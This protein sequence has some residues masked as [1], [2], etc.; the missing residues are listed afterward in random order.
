MSMDRLQEALAYRRRGFSVIPIKPKDKKPLIAWEAYQKEPAEEATIKHWFESWP[1]ANIGLV[2]GAVSDCIVVDLDSEDAKNKLKSL[3][4]DYDHSAVPRSRTGKGWQLFFKHPGVSIPNRAGVLPNVDIRAD[5]GYV[6]VPPSIHPNGKEYKWEVSFNGH[7]PKLPDE[8]FKLISAHSGNTES[9][10]RERFDTAKA[11]AGVPKGQR[12]EAI[13]KLASKLRQADVPSEMTE[14]LVLEAARN[15][16]PPF[17]ERV[18]LDKVAR[19]YQRYE[20]RKQQPA[21]KQAEIWPE[22]LTAKD[23]LQAPKD[24]T[25]WILENCLPV[26][27]GSIVV[28][29]PK[30]GKSTTVVDLC[31]SVARGERFLNRETQQ[32]PVAYLFLDGPLPEIADI[33]V[34]FGLRESD[35]IY[36]HAGSAPR[37]CIDWLLSTVK[38]KGVRLV[39]IDTLQKLLKFKDLNDYAEVTNRMEPLLDAARQGNCHIMMLHHAGKES[40]DDLDAAIGST[41]IRGLCYTYLFLKRLPNSERRIFR[42]DQRGGKN[43][44]ETAI[45]FNRVTG[46]VEI[47]GTMEDAEMDETEP[48]I[49]ELLESAEAGQATEKEIREGVQAR[50]IIVSK[51]LRRMLKKGSVERTGEGKKKQPFQYSLAADLTKQNGHSWIV[52]PEIGGMGGKIRDRES[53]ILK[54]PLKT[55]QQLL[56]PK[57]RDQAGIERD[58]ESKR[59]TRG[60]ENPDGSP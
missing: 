21:A 50:R 52:D 40:R 55:L 12:D 31:M 26:G 36:L 18:A 29:K 54:K 30:I 22:F 33:F 41:A 20:P 43:F 8:L 39:V 1:T 9:G 15:C 5:G 57:I 13:F 32:G 51:A 49:A 10:Y 14:T 16:Q 11:L 46:R 42:S 17:S 2:T 37:D 53:K 48:K 34:A 24:P 47:Q 23:I 6:V 4:G 3:L 60:I 59:R 27:G 44:P 19:V 25:R 35:P 38:E 45:G 58:R 28:A 56:I 7:L